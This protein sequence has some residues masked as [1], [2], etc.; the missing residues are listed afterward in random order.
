MSTKPPTTCPA[1]GARAVVDDVC[2]RCGYAQGESNRCP[3]CNGIAR[4]E[5]KGPGH[6]VCA[7]CGGP[8]LPGGLG[9]EA[10]AKALRE[11]KA[12]RSAGTRGRAGAWALGLVAALFTA[13]VAL[14][15][16]AALA[17][18]V[19]MTLVALAPALLAVRSGARVAGATRDADAAHE[20]A[21]LAAAQALAAAKPEGVTAKELGERLA[22]DE[23]RADAL[24]TQLA[25]HDQTRID[26]GDDAE[27]R[28]S[29]GPE[30]RIET[31][32]R[33]ALAEAEA[34]AEAEAQADA[35]AEDA[36]KGRR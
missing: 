35:A 23:A 3:H 32:E 22:I 19:V 33:E 4:L 31:G 7:I 24:L 8:R 36:A 20:R 30:V 13:M 1:C 17:L 5:P 16:P 25:V 34:E 11:E 15:W 9:G 21:L 28:Y 10:A 26:V 29:V 6:W 12:A 18:K 14:A 2:G 27:V